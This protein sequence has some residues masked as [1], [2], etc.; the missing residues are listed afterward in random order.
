MRK[1][2]TRFHRESRLASPFLPPLNLSWCEQDHA[3]IQ[4]GFRSELKLPHDLI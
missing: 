4:I 2:I 1:R 3:R